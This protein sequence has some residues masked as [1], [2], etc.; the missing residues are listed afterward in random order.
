MRRFR[1]SEEWL[2]L[3]NE[4]I[5]NPTSIIYLSILYICKTKAFDFLLILRLLIFCWFLKMM[6]HQHFVN[7]KEPVY[8][9]TFQHKH[10]FSCYNTS[11]KINQHSF[12]HDYLQ[13]SFFMS[14]FNANS[15]TF[16]RLLKKI[17]QQI[18]SSLYFNINSLTTERLLKKINQHFVSH[19]WCA[20]LS[21]TSPL[22]YSLILFHCKAIREVRFGFSANK[23]FCFS[24][25][26]VTQASWK[27]RKNL[28][29]FFSLS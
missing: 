7:F 18:F 23:Y 8:R 26:R 9:F 13:H 28:L 14:I 4:C 17:K 5:L 29:F 19:K 25:S 20:F 12:F 1:F 22:F 10:K 15:P 24:T 6:T 2:E 16:K 3:I 11:S 27:V 21:E